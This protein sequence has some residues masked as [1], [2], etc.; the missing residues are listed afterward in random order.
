MTAVVAALF[1]KN[2]RFMICQR[3]QTKK[4]GLLWEFVGG[5]VEAGETKEEALV[6]ECREELGIETSVGDEFM[7]VIHEYPDITIELTVF[8]AV[9][10]KGEPQ[11]LEHN[12]IKW[13]TPE[14]T[15]NY[16][17]C[18]ADKD[19][20]EKIMNEKRRNDMEEV[21]EFLK[22]CGT[23]YL[24]TVEN[25][26]PK[27]RPFGTVDIYNGK[28]HIQTGKK[29][30]VSKQI[31]ENPW[32]EITAFDG[33]TWL[34]LSGRAIEDEDVKAQEHMLDNYPSLKRMY[35]AGDGNTEVFAIEDG[36]AVF[37]SFTAPAKTI[38]L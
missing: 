22:K 11:K 8:H 1:E 15:E 26:R 20:L 18:P 31:H 5:K 35:Q 34:R 12:D 9:I 33:N 24:A 37:A 19:I 36:E 13:I 4:R 27:V 25:G 17:F 30:P 23:Y 14:E 32:I 3:P 6:R 28:L 16:D 29:K 2:G 21:Y 10:A 38:K 7:C